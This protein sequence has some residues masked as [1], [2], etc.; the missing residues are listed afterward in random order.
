[1]STADPRKSGSMN[2]GA[3]NMYRIA[4][5][6]PGIFTF[7]GDFLKGFIPNVLEKYKEQ[8]MIDWLHI[9]LNS[10]G[11][12]KEILEFFSERLTKNS[13]IIFMEENMNQ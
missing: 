6:L 2:P 11:A 12:T 8:N 4:G 9:D 7:I 1:M 3:T 13:I 5:P 10:S